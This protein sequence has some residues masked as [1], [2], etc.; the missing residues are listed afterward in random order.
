MSLKD[1]HLLNTKALNLDIDKPFAEEDSEKVNQMLI[2]TDELEKMLQIL[3]LNLHAENTEIRILLRQ[4]MD[5]VAIVENKQEI[6]IQ[7]ID[8]KRGVVS[9]LKYLFTGF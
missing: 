6:T 1:H 3:K 4:I 7:K 8:S 5:K 9:R 2:R